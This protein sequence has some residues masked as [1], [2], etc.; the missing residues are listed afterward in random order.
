MRV[1]VLAGLSASVSPSQASMPAEHRPFSLNLNGPANARRTP[2]R[3]APPKSAA[4]ASRI[5][6]TAPGVGFAAR[7]P[8]PATRQERKYLG[9][10]ETPALEL[11]RAQGSFVFDATGRKYIDFVMGWC[12]GNFGWANPEIVRA[13]QR[14]A[15]PDYV[16][17]EWSY[18]P[19][20]ELAR[21][22]A[23]I[24]PGRLT[25]SFRA[26]GGSEAVELALQAALVH[27]GRRAF[28]ALDGSYHGNTL[29]TLS[30]ADSEN[31]KKSAAS[32][33]RLGGT[34]AA[35]MWPLPPFVM[36]PA[37]RRSCSTTSPP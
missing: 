27:T 16:Y 25:K 34:P 6:P 2:F 26:T 3:N 15:G 28:V 12:V 30:I 29:G 31:R 32:G 22:L 19:W 11:S 14:Y 9:S 33:R 1:V 20:G 35:S 4:S 18:A 21:L 17:P 37:I 7:A 10:S 13:V 23:S 24:A 5:K 8:M 36:S